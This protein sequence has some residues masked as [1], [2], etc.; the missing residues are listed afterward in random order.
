MTSSDDPLPIAQVTDEEVTAGVYGD[1]EPS[2]LTPFGTA[3]MFWQA[4]DDPA[5]YAN[6]LNRLTVDPDDWG[7]FSEASNI[8]KDLSIMS[9]VESAPT[10]TDVAYVKFIELT[11]EASAQAFADAPLTDVRVVTVIKPSESD[12]W[13]VW[14][15]THNSFPN[16]NDIPVF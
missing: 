11:G 8:L 1:D 15:L 16:E 10:R 12:W 6:A 4:L 3:H 2:P 13:L 9:V 5:Y 14:S 7:D